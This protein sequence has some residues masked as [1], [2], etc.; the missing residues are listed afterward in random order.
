MYSRAMPMYVDGE[1]KQKDEKPKFDE[2]LDANEH[3]E[4]FNDFEEEQVISA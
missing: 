4:L 3:P 1:D 2:S